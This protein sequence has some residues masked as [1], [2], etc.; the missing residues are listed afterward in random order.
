MEQLKAFIEKAKSDAELG[1]K[2]SALDVISAAADEYIALA[3]EAGF[4]IT[5]DDIKEKRKL[6]EEE[7]ED[8]AGGFGKGDNGVL[9]YFTP[10]GKSNTVY[11]P[12]KGY[13]VTWVECNSW[14]VGFNYDCSCHKA[15]AEGEAICVNRW[16]QLSGVMEHLWPYGS[17]NHKK[18]TPPSYNT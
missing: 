2:L 4:T 8:V 3:A 13:E 12:D 10:T 7:L 14:C 9:C 18:K 1:E 16:H 5:A 6:T 17:F 15:Q 11:L